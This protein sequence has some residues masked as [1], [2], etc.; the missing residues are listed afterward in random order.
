MFSKVANARIGKLLLTAMLFVGV[1]SEAGWSKHAYQSGKNVQDEYAYI[2]K[3]GKTVFRMPSE[4]W[5]DNFSNGLLRVQRETKD[6]EPESSY[7]NTQGKVVVDRIS[8]GGDFSEGLAKIGQNGKVGFISKTGKV[9]IPQ[10]FSDALCFRDGLAP[11]VI[12][13]G[14]GFI[15]QTGKIVIDPFFENVAGFSEGLAAVQSQGKI[16]FIDVAGKWCIK[17]RFDYVDGF[18]DGL[19]LVRDGDDE[20]Y[21]DHLGRKVITLDEEQKRRPF[22]A[23]GISDTGLSNDSSQGSFSRTFSSH[24]TFKDG[25]SPMYKGGKYGYIDKAGKFVIPPKFQMAYPFVDGLASVCIHNKCGFI[26]KTGKFVVE[27]KFR[28]TGDFS[29]GAAAVAVGRNK[30]GYIDA[31]GKFIIEP[32]YIS[33]APFQDGRARVQLAGCYDDECQ[34]SRD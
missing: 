6:D 28:R 8:G 31:T 23:W 9:V 32:K 21:I 29:E 25:L 22:V 13:K 26:D 14:C 15:N 10:I 30:W 17:P 2:D 5:S 7:L 27:P 11:V 4:V 16:G 20:F 33:V 18:S 19:A 1:L 34:W 3:R 24:C 12:N